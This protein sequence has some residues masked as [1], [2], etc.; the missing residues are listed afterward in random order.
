[1]SARPPLIRR[2]HPADLG[3]I[4]AIVEAAYSPYI[5][6][7]GQ[8]PGPMLDDYAALIAA[9]RVH[10]AE[11]DGEVVALLVLLPQQD[12]MLLD[13]I[14]VSPRAQGK[15]LGRALM[16]LAEAE[17]RAAGFDRIRLYTNLLMTENLVLYPRLGY[18]EA[19][20]VR[21]KGFDRVYF[22]KPI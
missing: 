14:A 18:R 15:G 8:K 3:Q 2:A 12:A 5:P 7:M 17:A 9:E 19:L 6:R 16:D 13:N 4:E 22:E 1:M 20:R 21:E 10:V 11:I